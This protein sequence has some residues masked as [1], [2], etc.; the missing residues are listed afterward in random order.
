MAELRR[1]APHNV[2]VIE[3]WIGEHARAQRVLVPR[4]QRWVQFMVLLAA[5]DGVREHNGEPLFLLKGGTAMEL[6]LRT[7]ACATQDIDALFRAPAASV[8]A[9]LDQARRG[10]WGDFSFERGAP[11]PIRQTGSVRIEIKL[12]YRGR[13]WGTVPLEL[14]PAEGE[15]GGDVETLD[16]IELQQFGLAGPQRVACLGVRYQIAQKIHACTEPPAAGRR[17]DRPGFLG[18]GLF[19]R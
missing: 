5:L 12:S 18:D 1:Q 15:S 13:R 14:A 7:R 6:R 16:G 4:L 10:A 11:A 8:L 2:G 3:R 19:V 17:V 9:Q